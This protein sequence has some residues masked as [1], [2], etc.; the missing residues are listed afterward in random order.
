MSADG[1]PYQELF[2]RPQGFALIID[3][4]LHMSGMMETILQEANFQVSIAH[5][6][7]EALSMLGLVPNPYGEP[8]MPDLILL[9]FEMP[10][11]TGYEVLKRIREGERTR[12]VP[13]IM[14]TA[15]SKAI[16]DMV[17]PDLDAFLKKPFE[18]KALIDLVAKVLQKK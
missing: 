11:M 5:R 7:T 15:T 18:T 8:T 10:D 2:S 17:M 12:R 6:G 14:L 16:A 1:N 13:V 9:D 3:D 4:D